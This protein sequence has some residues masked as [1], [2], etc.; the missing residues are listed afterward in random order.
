MRCIADNKANINNMR[1]T[2]GGGEGEIENNNY[3]SHGFTQFRKQFMYFNIH[4]TIVSGIHLLSF[5]VVVVGNGWL[6][7]L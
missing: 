7:S 2:E 5:D 1:E 6:C 4:S 3:G